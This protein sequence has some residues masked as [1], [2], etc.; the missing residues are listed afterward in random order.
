MQL[1][2]RSNRIWKQQFKQIK[3]IS[4]SACKSLV[5]GIETNLA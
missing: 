5:T 1:K 3:I 2:S 4:I